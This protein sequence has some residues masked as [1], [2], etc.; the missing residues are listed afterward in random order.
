MRQALTKPLDR[1]VHAQLAD[2]VHRIDN[3]L[4]ARAIQ[5]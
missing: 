3:A 2:L 4:T 1:S 5:S